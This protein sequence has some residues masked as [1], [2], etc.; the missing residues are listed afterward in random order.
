LSLGRIDFGHPA[1]HG[2]LH[3]YVLGDRPPVG[4]GLDRD[5]VPEM[6]VFCRT[7]SAVD[8]ITGLG[9]QGIFLTVDVDAAE[10]LDHPQGRDARP[11]DAPGLDARAADATGMDT[12]APDAPGMDT[13]AADAIR[14][15]AR[16]TNTTSR[17]GKGPCPR[18]SYQAQDQDPPA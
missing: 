17:V 7:G 1:D 12:G 15:G 5:A 14:G 10:A 13:R 6:Q 16:S 8:A 18:Q 3:P 9:A 2:M 4:G 11:A